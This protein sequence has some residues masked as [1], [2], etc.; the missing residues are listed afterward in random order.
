[1]DPFFFFG[2]VVMRSKKR[3]AGLFLI[4]G[5]LALANGVVSTYQSRLS[6]EPARQLGARLP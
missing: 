1:M 5:V 2:Y 4:L 6:A 3:F